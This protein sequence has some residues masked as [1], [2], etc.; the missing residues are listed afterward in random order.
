MLYRRLAVALFA[1]VA[2]ANP[3][4]EGADACSKVRCKDGTRCE[5]VDGKAQCVPTGGEQC[6]AVTCGDGEYCCNDSC[7]ICS[8]I[9]AM[10]TM[11]ICQP[12]GPQCGPTKCHE[13]FEC[14]NESC[15][16]CV[17]EGEGACTQQV[18]ELEDPQPEPVQ[19]GPNTCAAG[20]EGEETETDKVHMNLCICTEPNGACTQQYCFPEDGDDDDDDEEGELCGPNIC[21]AGTTC[22][23]SSC[24][25][26][27]SPG[28]GCT[29][30]LC[31]VEEE[32]KP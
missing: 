32:G 19:C 29:K 9:G 27:T 5:V 4:P 22:C 11:Q 26:C 18:C 13:G 15:G 21:P 23:N 30:E 14:C 17:K 1:A 31:N 24:G 16:I 12:Q 6:G 10:C 20:E 7:S 3:V 25:Y 8:P 28:E 2:L